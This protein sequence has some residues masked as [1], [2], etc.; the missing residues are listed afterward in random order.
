MKEFENKIYRR[1]LAPVLA[2]LVLAL[3]GC[4]QD[5]TEAEA[6]SSPTGGTYLTIV[7]RGINTTTPTEYEDYVGKLRFLIF[8]SEGKNILNLSLTNG[9]SPDIPDHTGDASTDASSVVLDEQNIG[10]ISSG[11][12][13]FYCIANEDG[14][15]NTEDE[16]LSVA[17]GEDK[18]ISEEDL[19]GMQVKFTEND[20]RKPTGTDKYML[21]STK[22]DFLIRAG[23]ENSIT[24]V[25]DR[26]LAKAQL[27]IQSSDEITDGITASLSENEIP[28]SY[29]LIKQGTIRSSLST[30]GDDIIELSSTKDAPFYD[31][32]KSENNRYVSEVVYLPE[33]S[34]TDADDAL[35]YSITIG[36][37]SY[38]NVASI[39]DGATV[40]YDIKR[41]YA[42]TTI[43]TYSQPATLNTLTYT[44][45]P[46]GTGGGDHTFN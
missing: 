39:A 14:Y 40:D 21:M 28:G 10:Q 16:L 30:L 9:G 3:A 33:R 17:L 20:I 34:A 13:T 26:A 41:N 15:S 11:T 23:E 5:A 6:P 18:D 44:V 2:C 12:Y 32:A 42:Y 36:G 38:N 22:Q 25:L 31:E 43:C 46:W 29:S 27:V 35:Y 37:K 8:D 7:T 1:L 24:I 4:S 19:D 45:Q